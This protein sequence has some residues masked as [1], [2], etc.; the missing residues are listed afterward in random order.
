MQDRRQAEDRGRHVRD[1]SERAGE[2]GDDARAR[3][4]RE[5]GGERVEDADARRRDDDQRGDE[6]LQCSCFCPSF[7]PPRNSATPMQSCA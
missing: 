2:G 5:T 4:A 7:S 6:K 1:D 3:S